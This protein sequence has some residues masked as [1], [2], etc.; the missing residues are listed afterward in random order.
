MTVL[1]RF[2]SVKCHFVITLLMEFWNI[3]NKFCVVHLPWQPAS[4]VVQQ[5]L[6]CEFTCVAIVARTNQHTVIF[7]YVP[8]GKGEGAYLFQ[9]SLMGALSRGE[10][11]F[12]LTKRGVILLFQ[13]TRRWCQFSIKSQNAKW[14]SS[15][16][17]SDNH[18]GTVHVLFV[19]FV[20]DKVGPRG[21][22]ERGVNRGFT[23]VIF[24]V[25]LIL[26]L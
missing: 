11:L 19:D 24:I 21:L 25:P 7:Q 5:L 2:R 22:L 23:I 8:R 15:L 16:S 6:S 17:K 1:S 20:S 18:T 12:N 3:V 26:I 10:S 4:S 13:T 9:A 14:K